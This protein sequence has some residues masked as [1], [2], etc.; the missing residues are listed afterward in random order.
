MNRRASNTSTPA[1]RLQL[2][3]LS[4]IAEFERE[5]VR[6]RVVAG[7]RRAKAEGKKLGRPQVS[8]PTDKLV[9][10]AHLSLSEAASSLGVSRSTLKRWRRA[11]QSPPAL[12][13][14][15][16]LAVQ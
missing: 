11:A 1:G 2:H 6:E 8:I 10:V 3:I 7:L 4:A 13:R 9:T 15:P 16:A 5:R 12:Q 14:R